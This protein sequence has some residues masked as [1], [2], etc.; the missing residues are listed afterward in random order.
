MPNERTMIHAL[1][2]LN[3]LLAKTSLLAHCDALSRASPH[4]LD[5]TRLGRHSAFLWSKDVIRDHLG[6][7]KSTLKI[8]AFRLCQDSNQNLVV[9]VSS[10]RL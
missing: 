2:L 6:A 8:L 4:L 1:V 3:D 10:Y 9:R 5:A 7:T